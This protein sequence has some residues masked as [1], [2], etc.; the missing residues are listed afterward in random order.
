MNANK[1]LLYEFP[2]SINVDE[3]FNIN[4]DKFPNTIELVGEWRTEVEFPNTQ[5]N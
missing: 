1:D 4:C 5:S 3:S 2:I